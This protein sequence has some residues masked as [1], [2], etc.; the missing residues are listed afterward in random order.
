MT[1]PVRQ[2]LIGL[3]ALGSAAATAPAIRAQ[4]RGGAEWTT[5][6]GDAQRT[7]WI[8]SDPRISVANMA[9][10]AE[11]FGPFKFLWKLKVD[12]DPRKPNP[13]TQAVLLDRIIGFRGFKSVAF[14]ATTSGTVYAIDTDF[15]T[16]LW[17]VHLNYGASLPPMTVGTA[18]CPAGVTAALTRPTALTVSAFG[19]GGGGAGRGGRSGGGVGEAGRGAPSIY[20]AGQGRGGG[21]PPGLPATPGAAVPGS[22]AAAAQAGRA[23]GPGGGGGGRGQ[24][25][26]AP[27]A[28]YAI[29]NDGYVRALN[30]QSGWDMFPPVQFLPANT[31]PAGAIVVNDETTGFLYAVTTHGCAYTPDAVWAVDL[32]SPKKEV[33]S[34]EARGATIAGSAGPAFGRDGTIYVATRDGSSPLSNSVVALEP[35][36]LKQK[37]VFTLAKADFVSAPIVIQHKEKD[38]LA[39]AAKDGRI[40]VL[41]GATLQVPLATTAAAG[42]LTAEGLASWQDEKGARWILA[43]GSSSVVAHRLVEESSGV[44]FQKGWTSRALVAPMTPLVVNGV[45]FALSSGEEE[46]VGAARAVRPSPAVLYALDGASGKEIWNSAKTITASARGGLS[47]GAGVVYVPAS[48]STLYAFGFPIEK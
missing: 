5:S 43:A 8:R 27:D 30:V 11:G 19:G 33:V 9:K 29:G 6:N 20:T 38:L 31:R 34:W 1:R 45:V 39:V 14:V 12:T 3:L 37:A 15:G 42:E 46:Q 13:L 17:K 44:A 32:I 16:E 48:D 7:S 10:G 21:A 22:A 26:G 40:F 35:K 23:G 24:A 25:T 28:A 41:D 4:G 18:E 2:V 36:T 47:A